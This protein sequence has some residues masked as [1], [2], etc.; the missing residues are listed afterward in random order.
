MIVWWA[1]PFRILR[2]VEQAKIMLVAI[3]ARL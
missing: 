1:M 2:V 3:S